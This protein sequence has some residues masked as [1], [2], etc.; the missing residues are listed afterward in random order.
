MQIIDDF[1]SLYGISYGQN[2]EY[3]TS[4][5]LR[6]H[7]YNQKMT[8]ATDTLVPGILP[9][10]IGHRPMDVLTMENLDFDHDTWTLTKWSKSWSPYPPD[11]S[12]FVTKNSIQ[13]QN[14]YDNVIVLGTRVRVDSGA[15]L[16]CASHHH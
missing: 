6:S 16:W 7:G 15:S 11:F 12:S 1:S 3:L 9:I 5:I 10:V 13:F 8:M 4:D 14:K 2:L